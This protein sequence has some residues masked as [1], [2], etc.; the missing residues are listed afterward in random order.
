MLYQGLIFFLKVFLEKQLT[1]ELTQVTANVEDRYVIIGKGN[2][3]AIESLGKAIDNGHNK[4]AILYWGGH[5]L[6]LGRCLREEFDMAH[7]R[8]QLIIAW[9]ITK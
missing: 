2:K 6:N 3:V 8:V 4:I 7:S 5:M 9:S 1:Y